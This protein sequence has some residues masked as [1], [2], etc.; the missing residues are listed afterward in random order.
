MQHQMAV[1][2]VMGVQEAKGG[3]VRRAKGGLTTEQFMSYAE[4]IRDQPAGWRKACDKADDYYDNNQ[5]DPETMNDLQEAGM[6]PL[7]NNLIKPTIDVVLGMEAKSRTDWRVT[8]DH[9]KFQEVAEA[10]SSEMATVERETRADRACSDAYAGEVK[11]GIGWVEVSRQSDPFKFKY[12]VGTPHRREI[13]WDWRDRDPALQDGRYLIRRRWFDIDEAKVYFPKH[14][15]LLEAAGTGWGQPW[16]E[17]MTEV[18]ELL[19]AFDQER[20]WTLEEWEYRDTIRRRICLYEAWYRQLRRGYV[21]KLP[22][23]RVVEMNLDNPAHA[24]A[25]ARGLIKPIPAIYSKWGMAIF[26]GPHKMVD[27]GADRKRHPYIPFW[28][29]RES[30]TGTPY[31]LIRSMISPQDEV[32]ARRRKLMWL[33]SAV[34]LTMDSDALDKRFNTIADVLKELA[35][36][37]AAII[38]N[39]DRK[40][41]DSSA[42]SVDQ[43]LQLAESQFKIMVNAEESIQKVA[44]I[45]N[46]ILGR[47]SSSTSGVA[48]DS[49]VEQGATVLAELNDNYRHSRRMVGDALLD[50]VREDIGNDEVEIIAGEDGRKK[51]SIILNQKV[52]DPEMGGMTMLKNQVQHAGVRITL[53]DVPSTPSYRKQQFTMLAEVIK[54]LSPEAQAVLTPYLLESS[55]LPKRQKMAQE[56]RQALNLPSVDGEDD[57]RVT[58]LLDQVQQL[59]GMLQQAQA[60]IEDKTRREDKELEIK[61]REVDVK[62]RE[63]EDRRAERDAKIE[64]MRQQVQVS[65]AKAKEAE[66]RA[67]SIKSDTARKDAEFALTQAVTQVGEQVQQVAGG[68]EQAK[69]KADATQQASDKAA[70][71]LTAALDELKGAL[72]KMQ[73]DSGTKIDGLRKD[74]AAVIAEETTKATKEADERTQKAVEKA[75]AAMAERQAEMVEALRQELGARRDL[76]GVTWKKDAE[77]NAVGGTADYGDEKRGFKVV[78]GKNGDATRLEFDDEDK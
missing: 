15:D 37:D 45:F 11:A 70:K 51:K 58:A 3:N 13:D 76:K 39:P 54:G 18:A 1:V 75:A 61:S 7:I 4:D 41:R 60:A 34:R 73:S 20:G 74:L 40:N 21:L 19:H 9:D 36:P 62:E 77:G 43:N 16:Y 8:S 72:E 10:L 57:P 68:V 59:T 38:L 49:L 29:Y 78:R 31:G 50:L 2:D 24:L 53:E 22:D 12:R 6:A 55:D 71:Q 63:L 26:A 66:A 33:L 69:Q 17:R 65:D 14:H 56:V 67:E 28:G 27:Y 35:R 5:I 23:G 52:Q 42:I 30:L 32:N 47:E 48:I 44:G 46:A 25:V 64:N